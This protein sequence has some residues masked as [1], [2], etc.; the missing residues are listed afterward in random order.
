MHVRFSLPTSSQAVRVTCRVVELLEAESG[1]GLSLR[2]LA[3]APKAELA[4]VRFMSAGL[5]QK[6]RPA[7]PV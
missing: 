1:V 5:G 7:V 4:I 3:L 6:Q 2:F